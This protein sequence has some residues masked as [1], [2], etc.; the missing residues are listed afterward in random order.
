MMDPAGREGQIKKGPVCTGPSP[1]ASFPPGPRFLPYIFPT[2]M[3]AMT[4]E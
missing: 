1:R 3:N 4:R 2:R